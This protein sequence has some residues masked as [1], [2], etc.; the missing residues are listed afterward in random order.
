MKL[1][2]R[3]R[4]RAGMVRWVELLWPSASL[5]TNISPPCPCKRGGKF[6]FS[7]VGFL[8]FPLHVQIW[9]DS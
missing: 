1:R 5:P 3:E 6:G 2:E 4:E 8:F 7:V 9:V